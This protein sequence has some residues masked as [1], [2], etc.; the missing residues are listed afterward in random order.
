ME[1]LQKV[2]QRTK[3]D[4]DKLPLPSFKDPVMEVMHIIGDFSNDMFRH[5]EGVTYTIT[6]SSAVKGDNQFELIREAHETFRKNIRST[7]PDFRP[8]DGPR[9]V[10]QSSPPQ[11]P[12][13]P[14]SPAFAPSVVSV[15]FDRDVEP[16]FLLSEE[17]WFSPYSCPPIYLD[18]V[19][20]R[21]RKYVSHLIQLMPI[22]YRHIEPLLG[23]CLVT[24]LS[25]CCRT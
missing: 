23:S 14:L 9:D 1:E 19:V 2:L 21:V 18:D 22:F 6:G 5:A 25:R 11:T 4:L 8:F 20:K 10:A 7:A 16:S 24:S 12:R 3:D 13:A 17:R 15:T